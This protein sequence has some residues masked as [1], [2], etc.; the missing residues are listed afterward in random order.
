MPGGMVASVIVELSDLDFLR[1][2]ISVLE[3]DF[4]CIELQG[5]LLP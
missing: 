1:Q 2:L 4:C 3:A 5:W